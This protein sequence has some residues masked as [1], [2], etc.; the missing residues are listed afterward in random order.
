MS[1]LLKRM[2]DWVS[3]GWNTSGSTS[4]SDQ[5]IVCSSSAGEVHRLPLDI[6]IHILQLLEPKDAARVAA[7]CKS[8]KLI[9][10]DNTLWMYYLKNQQDGLSILF[11]ETKI[12]SRS[13]HTA[14][15]RH[16]LSFM[17]IYGQRLQS[18]GAIIVDAG[19]GYCK[20]GWSKY[21]SPSVRFATSVE[22][23][24]MESSLDHRVYHFFETV[25]SSM[26]VKPSKQPVILTTPIG[27]HDAAEV[28][29]LQLTKAV[30]K[31]L[32]CMMVPTASI[33]SQTTLALF[34]SRRTS[35]I[36]VNIGFRETQVVPIVNTL[37]CPGVISVKVGG[38]HLT[39]YLR[40]RL[41][42]RN[43]QV[44]SLY[45]A[46]TLKENLCYVALDYWAEL[47][48]DTK[49]SYKVGSEGLYTLNK[50]RFQTGEILFK[51][52]IAG[53]NVI[54]LHQAVAS[55]IN[56][57]QY[58]KAKKDRNWYKTIVLAG[59]TANLPGL[60][61]RL[62]KELHDLLPPSISHGIRVILSPY[63]ADAAWHGAKMVGNL[64]SF[65]KSWCFNRVNV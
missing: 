17:H 55:C 32:V 20:I 60:A 54:G 44:P 50:E 37:T 46:R 38:L 11:A 42:R 29:S 28:S 23:G 40:R 35:G 34:A 2:R 45:T 1:R 58:V 30:I 13:P 8:W 10:F 57:C 19:A 9:V 5:T 56:S 36:L 15:R 4:T 7:V 27:L 47:R 14:I 18:P 31:A 65:Q 64:S 3:N 49:A 62:E 6:F 52:H 39:R 24:D 53:R 12:R 21:D 41:R 16:M 22:F 43:V 51:P 48:K 33:V 25:Y 63:G 59:G 61:E 26:H